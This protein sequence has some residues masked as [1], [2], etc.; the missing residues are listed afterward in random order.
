MRYMMRN[1]NEALSALRLCVT[2]L[3][4]VHHT[5]LAYCR[6][7]HFNRKHYLWSSA[8]IIDPHRWIGFDILQDFNDTYFMSLTFLVS[9]LFVLPSLQRKG[10]Y[11]Y[12]KDRIWRLG[13]PFVVCVTLIM[14]LAY[15][16]S[17]RQTGA[18]LSFGQ[19]WLGYFTRFGWPGGPAWFIWFLLTLDLMCSALIRL[20]PMLPQKLA[21]VPDLIVNHPVRCLAALLVAACAIYL[22]V[23][24]VV[25]SEQWFR[26]C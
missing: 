12:V 8:P 16:P 15:Y 19:Y 3:V 26:V 1:R 6:Y 23:L 4:L 5:V 9:G 13:L 14:P 2:L 18:D 22:P 20:W 17:I 10:T 25:G 24:V 7:G 11:R 21:R